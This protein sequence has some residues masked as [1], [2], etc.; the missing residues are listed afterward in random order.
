VL[1][2]AKL[3]I[4]IHGENKIFYEKKNKFTHIFS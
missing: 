2:Q 3:L 1:A 4:T